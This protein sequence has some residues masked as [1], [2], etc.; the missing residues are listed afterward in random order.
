MPIRKSRHFWN[1]TVQEQMMMMMIE[2]N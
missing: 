2:Q 1:N